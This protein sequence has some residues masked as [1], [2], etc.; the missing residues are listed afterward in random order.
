MMPGKWFTLTMHLGTIMVF[1]V[2]NRFGLTPGWR[3]FAALVCGFLAGVI[4]TK[5]NAV[6]P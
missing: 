6:A 1:V 4:V 2:N 3:L 5:P